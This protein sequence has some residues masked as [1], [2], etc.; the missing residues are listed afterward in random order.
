MS[1]PPN[2]TARANPRSSNS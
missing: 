1:I 2:L